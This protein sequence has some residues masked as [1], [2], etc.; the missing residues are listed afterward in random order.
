MDDETLMREIL[1]ALVEDTSS[2]IGRLAEAIQ[3]RDAPACARLAHY[4]KGACANVGANRI[5]ACLL[6]I[7]HLAAASAFAECSKALKI[8]Q[9]AVELLRCERV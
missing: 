1:A 8:L 9:E 7:E 2:Q 4:S 6:E 3:A 5:A